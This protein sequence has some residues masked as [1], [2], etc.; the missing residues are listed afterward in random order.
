MTPA[1][2]SPRQREVG[3]RVAAGIP[4]KRIALELCISVRTVQTYMNRILAALPP[5]PELT[6]RQRIAAWVWECRM[7]EKHPTNDT[8]AA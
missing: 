5:S 6:R 2:L 4:D 3:E 7:A 8:Q 1:D